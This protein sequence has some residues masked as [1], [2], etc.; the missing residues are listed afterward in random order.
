M[1]FKNIV[2]AVGDEVEFTIDG[3][4]Y[5]G[6]KAD[7]AVMVKTVDTSLNSV[8]IPASVS[9]DGTSYTVTAIA[10]KAF[11]GCSMAALIW[12][13]DFSLPNNA[14]NNAW[15]GSN[16]LLYV[17]SASYAPSTVKNV[18]ANGTASTI[19]LSDNGGNF[20][21]PQ[22][23]TTQKISYSHQYHM[24]TGGSGKGWETIALPFGVETITHATRG[25]IVPFAAYSQNSGKKPFWLC[26]FGSN[27]FVRTNSIQA[28]TP[29]IIAMPNQSNY[30]NN[31]I[32]AGEV[33]FT[34][35]NVNVAATPTFSGTFVPAFSLVPKASNVYVLN[36]NN[37]YVSQSGGYDAG[38]RFIS[39]LRDVRPFEAYISDISTRGVIEI[40][41][42]DGTTSM[43]NVLS[44]LN[45]D[46]EI[47]IY[48]LSGQKVK[49]TK[50][51]DIDNV[52]E[53]LPHGVYIV[54]GQK[55]LR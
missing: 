53:Q 27:G 5:Q 50:Q 44:L 18:I 37:S 31:Y 21:C 7:K 2:E 19:T 55:V 34:S 20:Y 46:R 33:T 12:N 22:T 51:N 41:I 3:T 16:F 4:T 52:M 13:T 26:K 1:N 39:N 8:E 28:Y 24:E 45:P 6:S 40:G 14:F 47:D 36:V 30:D 54:N 35:E 42:G 38:S 25:E 9:Y 32:L 49:R 23:F 17:K 29:Y 48:T 10:D 11:D 15:I 43:D